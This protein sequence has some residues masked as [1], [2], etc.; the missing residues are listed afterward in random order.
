MAYALDVGANSFIELRYFYETNQTYFILGD[1]PDVLRTVIL[2]RQPSWAHPSR[3]SRPADDVV[4]M[5]LDGGVG[6]A[7][8]VT[9][10]FARTGRPSDD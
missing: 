7:G 3:P 6:E 9:T 1:F 2:E 10:P 4:A 8:P 5:A